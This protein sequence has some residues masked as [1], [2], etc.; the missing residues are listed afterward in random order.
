MSSPIHYQTFD[1]LTQITRHNK[2]INN[3]Q[4][5]WPAQQF[6]HR[7]FQIAYHDL[8][9]K[10]AGA[11]LYLIK[12]IVFWRG[13]ARFSRLKPLKKLNIFLAI[14]ISTLNF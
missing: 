13:T 9:A 1:V 11:D 2:W 6:N 12:I 5:I 10:P 8:V 4:A 7:F 14:T 3:S